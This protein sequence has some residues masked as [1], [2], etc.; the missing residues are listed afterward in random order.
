MN[1]FPLFFGLLGIIAGFFCTKTDPAILL[2]I[3]P[4][5]PPLLVDSFALPTSDR[6][7]FSWMWPLDSGKTAYNHRFNGNVFAIKDTI[8][9]HSS[10]ALY[11]KNDYPEKNQNLVLMEL[12]VFSNSGQVIKTISIRLPS[13]K[14]GI[15]KGEQAGVM[16]SYYDSE[17]NCAVISYYKPD[18]NQLSFFKVVSYDSEKKELKGRFKFHFVKT[19]DNSGNHPDSIFF[20]DGVVVA[21]RIK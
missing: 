1:R 17:D 7:A 5:S 10:A 4:I 6:I 15:Y 12:K 14:P 2:D 9:W 8:K 19:D 20:D 3:P 11:I 16:F 18:P 13:E 21:I